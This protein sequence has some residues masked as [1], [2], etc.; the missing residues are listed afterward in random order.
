MKALQRC[1]MFGAALLLS[2]VVF[3]QGLPTARP[4]SVGMSSERLGR[5]KT[6]L[7][8]E[9]D[10]DRMPG[11]VVMIA[12]NGKLVYSEAIGFQDKAAGKPMPK[13]AIFRIYSMTKPLASVAAM[14]LV[15]EGRL[16]LTDPVSRYLPPF[17]KME[18]LVTDKDGKT[19]R[20]PAKRPITVHDLFRHTAGLA[21]GE[22]S[23]I[24]ELKAA[25]AEAKL[26]QS[27]GIVAESRL[28]TPEQFT[29]GIAKAPLVHQPGTTWEY[30]MAVDVLGRVVEAV[31]GQP[32]SAFLEDR[33]F[34]PLGMVDT[35][36]VVPAAKSARIAEPLAKDPLTGKPND[37]MLDMK[38]VPLNDSGGGGAAS[39]AADYLRFCQMMLDGGKLDG[40]RYLSPTTVRLMASDHLG[41]RPGSPLTPGALLMGVEGYTFG[42]GF[43]VRQGA[44]LAGVPGS[45]GEFMWAGAGGTFFWIDPKEQ[46]AVV[47]MAQTPGAIRP[48]YRRLIK[49]L[50][51][52]AIG[53]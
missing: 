16:Q 50:V 9:I 41:S 40:K 49:Q 51:G 24:P 2:G 36:F 44:G 43:M 6:T 52:Q 30:S 35:G 12:R 7:Q 4:E 39:T 26:F 14:M 31:S 21:Y 23:T 38:L 5:I 48:V 17:A 42:L 34:R 13:D 45:E 33:L 32:L 15:E 18:V 28:I 19:T 27:G 22:F 47:Y 25:Y 3:S 37:V 10:A 11:A 53:D 46:L 29:N 20:E 1:A 8:R